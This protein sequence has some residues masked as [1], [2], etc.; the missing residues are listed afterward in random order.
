MLFIQKITSWH[1]KLFQNP[2]FAQKVTNLTILISLLFSVFACFMNFEARQINWE[3]WNQNKSE[4]FVED[5][6]LFTTMDAGYFLGIA[7]YL[8]SGK[9]MQDYQALRSFP[10]NKKLNQIQNNSEAAPLLSKIIAFLAEENSPEALL[11][12]GNKM[13]PYTAVLTV[14]SIFIAFAITGYWLEA[15]VAAAGGG[16]SLAYYWRSSIGRIDTDQ[17]NLGFM[18]LIFALICAQVSLKI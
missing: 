3:I 11:K 5:T 18:Y 15:S 1:E 8:K 4:F 12:A 9:T 14:I 7:G 13:I 6:P 10:L 16:L 17:L 2:W